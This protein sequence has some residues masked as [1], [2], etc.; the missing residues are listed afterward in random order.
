MWEELSKDQQPSSQC[1]CLVEDST[2]PG[3]RAH[4]YLSARLR[5]R[6]GHLTLGFLGIQQGADLQEASLA[7]GA[8]GGGQQTVSNKETKDRMAWLDKATVKT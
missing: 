5:E 2:N 7:W 6:V 3:E 8:L 1:G 4:D